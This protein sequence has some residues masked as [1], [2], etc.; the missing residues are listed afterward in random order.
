[1]PMPTDRAPQNRRL[2]ARSMIQPATL[3]D[4]AQAIAD[5]ASRHAPLVYVERH[6]ERWRWS[7]AHRGGPYPLLRE[8]ARFLGMPPSSLL[9]SCTC[10]DGI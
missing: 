9:M 4:V 1:M 8:T 2:L 6:G 7:L 10:V 5:A 3:D